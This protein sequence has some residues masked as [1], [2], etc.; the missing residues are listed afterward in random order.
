MAL[1][2]ESKNCKKVGLR[3]AEVSL[4]RDHFLAATQRS[5]RDEP[6]AIGSGNDAGGRSLTAGQGVKEARFA[7]PSRPQY[8]YELARIDGQ[9]DTTILGEE[10]EITKD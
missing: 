4:G 10:G 8:R 2:P 5:W 3:C 1:F 9:G 7:S 6:G